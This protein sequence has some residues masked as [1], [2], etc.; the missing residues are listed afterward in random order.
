MAGAIDLQALH[1]VCAFTAN[2]T[3]FWSDA[4]TVMLNKFHPEPPPPTVMAVVHDGAAST[5]HL[6]WTAPAA[7]TQED[8]ANEKDATEHGAYAIAIAAV[9]HRGY[10]VCRRTHQGSGADLLMVRDGEPQ[11]DFVKLEVSG[12][13][14]DGSV[15]AR[16]KE[17]VA[18]VRGGDLR[19]PGVAAV[20]RFKA[21]GVTMESTP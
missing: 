19:R 2:T 4:A 8:H 10:R 6:T 18:E 7:R 15:T 14:R 9:H 16:L 1:T 20:V 5:M 3:N 21:A 13:A 17:K 12:I 11:N